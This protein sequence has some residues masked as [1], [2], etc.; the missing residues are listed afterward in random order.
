MLFLHPQP[1]LTSHLALALMVILGLNGFI[2]RPLIRSEVTTPEAP[3]PPPDIN[4]PA[5]ERVSG[6]FGKLPLGFELNVGQADS[7]VKFLSRGS[8]YGL[9]LLPAEAVLS[10]RGPSSVRMKFINGNPAPRIEGLDELP[11]KS[12]FFIGSNPENWRTNVSS[13]A[14]V[15]YKDLYPAI[16]MIYYGDQ[17][18]LKYD[19]IVA[20][21][22]DPNVIRFGFEGVKAVRM[23]RRGDLILRTTGGELRQSKPVIYQETAGSRQLVEGRYRLKGK[24]GIGFEIGKYDTSKPLVI[25]PVLIYSTFLGGSG[26][27]FGHAIAVDD[28]GNAYV[29][30]ETTSL[31]FP[32]KN[33]LQPENKGNHPGISDVFI[34]KIN[35]AGSAVIYSTYLGGSGFDRGFAI[36]VDRLG[37]A[38][39]TGSTSSIDFPTR[40]PIQSQLFTSFT[41]GEDAFVTK[42]SPSGGQLVFSTYLGGNGFDN[43]KAIAVDK[44]KNVYFTGTTTDWPTTTQAFQPN[45][46]GFTDAFV[47]KLNSAGT[48][49]L[50]STYL[51]G[52]DAED[53]L[54]ITV[55]SSQNAY[56]TGHT[57]SAFDFPV[58][59]ALQ[60]QFGGGLSDAF[61]AKL[62]TA[63]VTFA[64]LPDTFDTE[65]GG[66]PS[67]FY[68]NFS[69][70]NVTRG[71]VNLELHPF[72]HPGLVVNLDVNQ[73]EGATI[74]TKALL[75]LKPVT[76]R[77]R[78]D[79]CIQNSASTVTVALGNVFTE[80]FSTENPTSSK[81]VTILRDIQ[82]SAAVDAKLAIDNTGSGGGVW[83]DNVSVFEKHGSEFVTFLGGSGDEGRP[84]G[85]FTGGIK[86]DAAGS[87]YVT[88]STDSND[89][90]KVNAVQLTPAGGH[91][92]FISKLNP[93]GSALLYSTFFG[94]SGDDVANDL[95]IDSAGSTFI[96]GNT[97]STDF[98]T[99]NAIQPVFGGETRFFG[100]AFAV[101]LSSSGGEVV[102][103]TYLGN[104]G[105]DVAEGVAVDSAGDAF[106]TGYTTSTNFPVVNPL[107]GRMPGW[108]SFVSKIPSVTGTGVPDVLGVSPNSVGNTG[109][110]TFELRGEN[111]GGLTA[112]VR[113]VRSGQ[114]EIR[115]LTVLIKGPALIVTPFDL[116]G[117]TPGFWDMVIEFSDGRT[118]HIVNAV[119]V[120]AGG[121]PQI[122]VDVVGPHTIRVA[123][124]QQFV[125]V[126]GNKGN[127]DAFQVPLWLKLP[128]NVAPKLKEALAPLPGPRPNPID[129]TTVPQQVEIGS[130]IIIPI[131]IPHLPANSKRTLRFEINPEIL[132]PFNIE[133]WA[134]PPLLSSL[135]LGS[136]AVQ[137]LIECVLNLIGF[138]MDKVLPSECL[139][140]LKQFILGQLIESAMKELNG[141]GDQKPISYT[142]AVY[143]W[144]FLVADCSKLLPQSAVL[145]AVLKFFQATAFGAALGE[146]L[147]DCETALRKI[148]PNVNP[149]KVF[150]VRAFDPNDKVGAIGTGQPRYI[151]GAEPLRY[152]VYFENKQTASAPAQ[153]VTI[154]D[155]LDPNVLDLSSFN[156]GPVSF[157]N[158]GITP[159]GT[160][161]STDVDLRPE[162]NLIVRVSGT[163]DTTTGQLNWKFI[164]LDPATGLPPTDPVVGFLPPNKNPPEGDGSVFF[165]VSP[166]ANLSTG[167]VINNSAS[168]VFD[169]NAAIATGTWSNT[170]DN[171]KPTS[172]VLALPATH[173]SASFNVQWSGTDIGS[174]IGDFDVYVSENGGPFTPWLTATSNT[175]AI[176]NSTANHTYSFFSIARDLTGNTEALKSTAEASTQVVSVAEIGGQVKDPYGN[177]VNRVAMNLSGARSAT[178]ETNTAGTFTFPNLPIGNYTVTPSKTNY[179]FTPESLT[180]GNLNANH[181]ANFVATVTPGAPILVTEEGSTR[182][183]ALVSPL[184][185]RDP[186]PLE[187]PFVLG[188]DRRTRVMLF[189]MNFDFQ[190]SEDISIIKAEAEDAAHRIYPL[191]VEHVGRVP[192]LFWL[193]SI[194]IRL[195]DDMVNLGDVLLR[196]N[197]R[198]VSSNRVRLG[199][200]HTGGGPPD[201]SGAVPAPGREP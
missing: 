28:F 185:L 9:F 43:G 136:P 187:F 97:K 20:P 145:Q 156:F 30:G 143:D 101:K 85:P 175:Q 70:W 182:A 48:Q 113:L 90:P 181:T 10:L 189:V 153:E 68:S 190:P 60:P 112:N 102:Y 56:V 55:D 193:N 32:T 73:P 116:T 29:A 57:E 46:A 1:Q 134:N 160:A 23:D 109:I 169:N 155:Q 166:K 176:F 89:F 132:E 191:T 151:T 77:L 62:S 184:W 21:G 52:R 71:K 36:A 11:G 139:N 8:G 63:P 45:F 4:L 163:F 37:S 174:G 82:V 141:E 24:H 148:F 50:Y 7:R 118:K 74:E 127:T 98:P 124:K 164:S 54:A 47:T 41:G 94:G 197:V 150:V 88:G 140:Q 86:V 19:L 91:D 108:D 99:R 115:P 35:A 76:Y 146:V 129:W 80:T 147:A 53:G 128:K 167:T 6:A 22:A 65:N 158:R 168:I 201:D 137:S 159:S 39:I 111:F 188:P 96:V 121:A 84:L 100:D 40:N 107:Q 15:R 138:A 75:A 162:N 78:F 103:S 83:I 42:L 87:L 27:D 114:S 152:A 12:N 106:L 122:W 170:L 5:T 192:G 186:F 38:Y 25:D 157:G 117:V 44:D 199:I 179:A 105:W 66:S 196:I 119:L 3:L 135:S 59:N 92:L 14:K 61:V 183:L 81:F 123:V 131:L 26:D 178:T 67:S 171:S 144:I 120:N 200:G 95:A 161:F 79:L 110:V 180:V 142:Q 195:N 51:G 13:Y 133:V 18:N 165:T 49:I 198:G 58:R 154:T 126:C 125:M 194:V 31:D 130:D 2:T 72:A 93:S 64:F 69:N 17:R 149:L 16:D 33:A 177:V 104:D 34:T 173:N 172:R